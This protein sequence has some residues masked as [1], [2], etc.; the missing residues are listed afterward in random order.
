MRILGLDLGERRTG[1]ALSDPTGFLA[2]P[3]TVLQHINIE[4]DLA[5][6][7]ELV[8]SRGVEQVVVG[9]PLSLNGSVGPQ[10]R[11][12][13]RRVARLRDRLN[14]PIVLWDE[15]LSTVEA[16]RLV[17]EAGKRVKRDRIDA[18]AAAVILQSYLDAG[19]SKSDALSPALSADVTEEE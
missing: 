8:R 4:A 10:A 6:I 7:E 5:A 13:Q 1:V 11:L 14:V 3:L 16:K 12:V 15:S 9:L 18:A 19:P 17:H 2:T